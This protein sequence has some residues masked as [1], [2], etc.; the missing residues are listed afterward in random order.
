MDVGWQVSNG[1]VPGGADVVILK[2]WLIQYGEA[3]T[4]ICKIVASITEWLANPHPPWEEY[5]AL[6]E[7]WMVGLDITD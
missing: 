7:G 4:E 2:H 5:M 3:S 6:M 1:A